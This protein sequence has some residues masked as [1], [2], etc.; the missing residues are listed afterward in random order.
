MRGGNFISN[1]RIFENEEFGKVRTVEI[2]GQPYSVGKDI[3]TALGYSNPRKALADHVD[4][5]DKNDGVTIRDSIGREQKPTVINESGLYSLVLS[6][7]LPSAKKFKRWVTMEVLPSIR[8]TGGDSEQSKGVVATPNQYSS[9]D[10]VG[11]NCSDQFALVMVNE[12]NDE[13]V[14]SGRALHQF[15]GIGTEYMKWLARMCEYGFAEGT[16]FNSVKNDEVRLEGN[17]EVKREI[18]DHILKLD[19]AKELCMLARS[20]KGKQARRYFLELERE[21]NSPEKV[22]ARALKIAQQK[23]MVFGDRI[24]LLEADNERMRPKE[25]FADAVTG[26]SDTIP[27]G[28]LAKILRQNGYRIGRN[29]LF[30]WLRENGYLIQRAGDSYNCPTQRAMD[31]GL[32]EIKETVVTRSDGS[33]SVCRTPKVTGKGQIYFIHKFSKGVWCV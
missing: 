12:Q 24:K 32:F 1:L 33:V 8:K 17:R 5:E 4:S 18:T 10:M 30:D 6:S 16:D 26:S 28:D 9:G 25:I 19:M 11:T 23:L 2:K 29:R 14:V 22:M 21:W 3:A 31:I 7:K 20:D 27:I 15:L 13:Q